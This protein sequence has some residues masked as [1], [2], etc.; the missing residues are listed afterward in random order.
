MVGAEKKSVINYFSP[1]ILILITG[2][3][4]NMLLFHKQVLY[5]EYFQI[6]GKKI[7]GCDKKWH[8]NTPIVYTA[9]FF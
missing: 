5:K 3:R 7:L 8:S 6:D 4:K 1:K 2:T 9:K